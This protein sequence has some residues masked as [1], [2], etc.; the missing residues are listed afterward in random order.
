M[1]VLYSHHWRSCVV[2]IVFSQINKITRST[3]SL[4]YTKEKWYETDLYKTHLH[5]QHFLIAVSTSATLSL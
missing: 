4:F 5:E 2:T 1:C 3:T